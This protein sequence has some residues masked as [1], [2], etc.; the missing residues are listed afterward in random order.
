MADARG[1]LFPFAIWAHGARCVREGH[2][3]TI[4]R[5]RSKC[6][7]PG[8]YLLPYLHSDNELC[9][10]AD[11]TTI[12]EKLPRKVNNGRFMLTHN[13]YFRSHKTL[14]G[15]AARCMSSLVIEPCRP[16]RDR[17]VVEHHVLA[18]RRCRRADIPSSFCIML[19][20]DMCSIFNPHSCPYGQSSGPVNSFFR[21]LQPT[22][23]NG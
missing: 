16:L 11:P 18:C 13:C 23:Q 21:L 19:T 2:Q 10:L 3:T 14:G 22:K 1:K 6:R 20:P 9:V 15:T 5:S 17:V 12:A 7:V 8:E 4:S